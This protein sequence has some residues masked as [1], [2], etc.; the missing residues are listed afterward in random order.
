MS[1]SKYPLQ[2]I[3]QGEG[4]S[5]VITATES[6]FQI[7]Y[8]FLHNEEFFL[9]DGPL[10]RELKAEG[11]LHVQE[12]CTIELENTY[13]GK[14]YRNKDSIDEK[15]FLNLKSLL[16]AGK[17]SEILQVLTGL[18]ERNLLQ[19]NRFINLDVVKTLKISNES[20][21]NI[22]ISRSDRGELNASS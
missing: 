9:K 16:E 4:K 22:K 18:K 11:M 14:T 7:I 17:Y 10:T 15:V 8:L 3:V 21:V 1:G 19:N 6:E 2:I 12:S 5:E 13:N 20:F